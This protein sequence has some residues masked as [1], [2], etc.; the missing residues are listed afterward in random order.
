MVET[1][2]PGDHTM[3]SFQYTSL[4]QVN[5]FLSLLALC[6]FSMPITSLTEYFGGMI[7]TACIW[8]T[9]IFSSIIST[10]GIPLTIFGHSFF[11]YSLTPVFRIRLRYFGIHTTWYSVRYTECPDN[12]FSTIHQYTKISPGIIH[13]RASPWNSD[14]VLEGTK[15]K[16][17]MVT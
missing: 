1:K 12:L 11:R 14:R 13:P 6:P 8:S 10:P 9:W 7:I 4:S 5:F 15:V 2:Y 17:N 3:F 16:W